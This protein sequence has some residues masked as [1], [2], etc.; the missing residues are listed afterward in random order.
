MDETWA[1]DERQPSARSMSRSVLSVGLCATTGAVVVVA[2]QATKAWA[3]GFLANRGRVALVDDWFGLRLTRNS[4]ASFSVLTDL[5]WVFTV[6]AIAVVIVGVRVARRVASPGW[7]V[8]LGLLL[9]GV[10][11]N[12]A[13]RL[14]RAPGFGQG[15]VVDFLE[16]PHWP[17]FNLADSCIDVA[18]VLIVLQGLR[19]IS[20]D[21]ARTRR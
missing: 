19:G 16:L 8:A 13:D 20:L 11:G 14:F 21:G 2:D 17:I 12:L 7:G 10:L 6:L 18:A 4:G 9:G 1:F 15:H 5:P 3:V